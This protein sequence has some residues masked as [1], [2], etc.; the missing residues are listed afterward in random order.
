MI[1][2]YCITVSG[3]LLSMQYRCNRKLEESERP[4][5]RQ[6]E[7]QLDEENERLDMEIHRLLREHRALCE[8]RVRGGDDDE[9]N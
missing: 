7:R 6:L 8:G 5:L 2:F 1:A 9:I 3:L 4:S